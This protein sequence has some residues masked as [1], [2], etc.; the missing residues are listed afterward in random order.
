MQNDVNVPSLVTK[1]NKCWDGGGVGI[2]IKMP[3]VLSRW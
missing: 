1:A 3:T 2:W